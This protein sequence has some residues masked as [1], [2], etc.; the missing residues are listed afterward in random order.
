MAIL[1][2]L[3]GLAPVHSKQEERN[4]S[5]DAKILMSVPKDIIHAQV[6][7][8]VV[9]ALNKDPEALVRAVVEAAMQEKPRDS[10]SYDKATI[11][12][13][14]VNEEIRKVATEQFKIWLEQQKPVIA[15]Q[16]QEFMGKST[17]GMVQKIAEKMADSLNNF[18]ININW[19]EQ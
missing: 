2:R 14:M 4:V 16:I 8:A 3:E 5:E 18:S 7:S 9:Q 1:V 11:W 15:K 17:K 6:Q 19:G 13:K 12:Q 10:Y